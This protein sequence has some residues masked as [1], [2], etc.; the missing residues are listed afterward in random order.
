MVLLSGGVAA[1]DGQI[2]KDWGF[3]Y[4]GRLAIKFDMGNGNNDALT[5]LIALPDGQGSIAVGVVNCPSTTDCIG[6]ARLNFDGSTNYDFGTNGKVVYA[7]FTPGLKKIFVSSA[8]LDVFGKLLI[9]GKYTTQDN[10]SG[11]FVTRFDMD[12]NPVNFQANTKNSVFNKF[13][14]G[15]IAQAPEIAPLSNGGFF[16][17]GGAY[18]GNPSIGVMKF[19][20]NGTIDTVFGGTGK[21]IY[22]YPFSSQVIPYAIAVANDKLVIVGEELLNTNQP[23]NKNAFALKIM[24]TTGE[25]DN[26]F[27]SGTVHIALDQGPVGLRDDAARAVVVDPN[28]DVVIAGYAQTA[29]NRY[30]GAL[31]KINSVG[32]IVF[33]KYSLGAASSMQFSELVRQDDGKYVAAGTRWTDVQ[34]PALVDIEVDRFSTDG[35]LDVSFGASGRSILDFFNA[36]FEVGTGL[37]IDSNGHILIGGYGKMLNGLGNDFMMAALTLGVIQ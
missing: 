37:A 15:E 11:Y 22:G 35:T 26:D 14:N 21:K 1:A 8:T 2:A 4:S 30:K 16:L 27:N 20:V 32:D 3:F 6:I 12:G 28:G 19:K 18:N 13:N 7:P 9:A 24:A 23:L 31:V 29:S 10:A 33:K 36:G 25:P 34:Q 17:A 5:D